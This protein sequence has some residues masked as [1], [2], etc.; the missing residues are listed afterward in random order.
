MSA[1]H[2]KQIRSLITWFYDG[3]EKRQGGADQSPNRGRVT[4]GDGNRLAGLHRRPGD[5]DAGVR[6]E[7]GGRAGHRT[8]EQDGGRSC[9]RDRHNFGVGG[10]SAPSKTE[11]FMA[12]IFQ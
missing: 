7:N 8:D 10:G 4:P 12:A 6:V 5:L 11:L 2:R 3:N 1:F 9:Q